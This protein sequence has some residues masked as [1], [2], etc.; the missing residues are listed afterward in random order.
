M[1]NQR[2]KSNI[3]H[4]RRAFNGAPFDKLNFRVSQR[5]LSYGFQAD[6]SSLASE[7]A[8]SDEYSPKDECVDDSSSIGRVSELLYYSGQSLD[9]LVA[10]PNDI[11]F[12]E[13]RVRRHIDARV[14]LVILRKP[15]LRLVVD[16]ERAQLGLH[17][18]SRLLADVRHLQCLLTQIPL[19]PVVVR[20][21]ILIDEVH[22][23]FSALVNHQRRR[24][25][26]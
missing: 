18:D 24:E 22:G 25:R 3:C 12:F 8:A 19:V 15:D 14:G 26:E 16:P 7:S 23:R 6:P 5:S 21:D 11:S 4:L 1:I 2:D 9:V 20:L 10:Q 17:R 13:H